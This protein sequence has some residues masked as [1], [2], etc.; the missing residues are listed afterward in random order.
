MSYH[1]ITACKGCNNN[2]KPKKRERQVLVTAQHVFDFDS[3]TNFKLIIKKGNKKRERI[4]RKQLL[5]KKHKTYID[6]TF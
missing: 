2:K 1:S 3:Q 5:T 6:T 4:K